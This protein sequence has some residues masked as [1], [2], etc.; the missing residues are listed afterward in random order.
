MDDMDDKPKTGGRLDGERS[1]SRR[2][3]LYPFG[4]ATYKMQGNLWMKPKS[5]DHEKMIYLHC[6]ADS[7][8][9]QLRAPHHDYYF[10]T[11]HSTM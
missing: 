2:V 11:T 8:L 4:L 3:P 1:R 7:W 6:A 10:F 9:K 5:S